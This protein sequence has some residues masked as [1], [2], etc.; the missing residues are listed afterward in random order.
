M[1]LLKEVEND[2]NAP[3]SFVEQ[4]SDQRGA[5]VHKVLDSNST[6]YAL[7]SSSECSPEQNNAYDAVELI[8]HESNILKSIPE[9][10]GNIYVA[11]GLVDNAA[12]LLTK[13]VSGNTAFEESK[14]IKKSFSDDEQKSKLTSLI[15]RFFESIYTIH[16][17]GYLHGDLQPKHALVK[18]NGSI[19]LIDYGISKKVDDVNFKYRGGLVH[20]CSPEVCAGMLRNLDAIPITI[21][22]EIYSASS[23]AFF[24]YTH[25]TSTFY[26][27]YDFQN[28]SFEN[29]L[30]SI[31]SDGHTSFFQAGANDFPELEDIISKCMEIE[32]ENR[33]QTL[34]DAIV[35][36]KSI[37]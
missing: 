16:S 20:F 13:W 25:K 27:G 12:W 35:D 19:Q 30:K 29:M 14:N 10:T 7:K 24:L 9:E 23:V 31:M 1:K 8:Q 32:P 26:G 15:T 21:A 11:D 5:T 18:A 33:Y 6:L 17:S 4:V 3:L 28:I 22:S 2:I 37:Y 34:S 36:L